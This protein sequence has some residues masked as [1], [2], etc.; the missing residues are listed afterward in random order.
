MPSRFPISCEPGRVDDEGVG[1]WRHPVDEV[2]DIAFVVGAVLDD[3]HADV[4]RELG[5]QLFE[6]S[7]GPDGPVNLPVPLPEIGHVGTVDDGDAPPAC[8]LWSEA[9]LDHERPDRPV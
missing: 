8:P 3:V 4:V 1:L 2:Q 6:I 9:A 5:H 7:Q